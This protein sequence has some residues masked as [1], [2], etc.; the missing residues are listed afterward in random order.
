MT[1][2]CCVDN[3]LIGEQHRRYQLFLSHFH[4]MFKKSELSFSFQKSPHDCE[5][6]SS[7]FFLNPS[8]PC[9]V[10]P[11]LWLQCLFPYALNLPTLLS[12]P[13]RSFSFSFKIL[14]LLY[15]LLPLLLLLLL[16]LLLIII[17]IIIII[18][19]LLPSLS[20]I[21]SLLQKC[22]LVGGGGG[23]SRA[24]PNARNLLQHF[25]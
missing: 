11:S 19:L 14:L 15:L 12:P 8:T 6:G 1:A 20:L 7:I 13:C 9:L 17:I 24:R 2:T 4:V 25:T 5:M 21:E 16:L 3:E 18:L 22:Q 10:G 23:G